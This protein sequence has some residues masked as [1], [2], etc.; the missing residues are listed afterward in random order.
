MLEKTLESPLDRKEIK[1]IYPKGNQSW[2]FIG[3][4]DAEAETPILWP[5]DV[6]NGL[7][8]KDPDAGEDWGQEEKGTTEDEILD[9]ITDFDGHDFE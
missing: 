8:G 3:R 9:D 5:P 7:I 1:P 2:I 4:T 6:K